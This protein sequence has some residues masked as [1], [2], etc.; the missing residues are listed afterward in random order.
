MAKDTK[1]RGRR[2]YLNDFERDLT[3]SYR[4]RGSHYRYTGSLSR[5]RALAGLW[6]LSLGTLALLLAAGMMDGPGLGRCFY[7]IIPY[8]AAFVASISVVYT[9]GRLS[10]NEDPLR[11]YVLEQTARKLPVRS[12]VTLAFSALSAAGGLV[13]LVL[14]GANGQR[15]LFVVLC[16]GAFAAQMALRRLTGRMDWEKLEE[17]AGSGE[18]ADAAPEGPGDEKNAD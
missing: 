18:P 7:V 3:G 12:A 11:E 10:F 13:Y 5:G 6:G 17:S 4:Y 2:A 8:A 16:A 9:V 14:N 15:V 1:K